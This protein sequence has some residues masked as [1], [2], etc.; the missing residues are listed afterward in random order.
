MEL[1]PRI[2]PRKIELESRYIRILPKPI[3]FENFDDDLQHSRNVRLRLL[4]VGTIEIYIP[5][6]DQTGIFKHP[7]NKAWT[8][9]MIL[10]K[11]QEDVINVGRYDA[12]VH[13]EHY[14]TKPE[15]DGS[16]F[17]KIYSLSH[18]RLS[19]MKIY[20]SFA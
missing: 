13:P 15:P 17:Y 12:A 8:L 2:Y 5:M 11:I 19:G 4:P 7:S 18:F 3:R 16:T 10:K 6:F 1:V 14:T 9:G 20:V